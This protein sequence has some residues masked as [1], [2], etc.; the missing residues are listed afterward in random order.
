MYGSSSLLVTSA[1][2]SKAVYMCALVGVRCP[3]Q[4]ITL[5]YEYLPYKRISMYIYEHMYVYIYI[6]VNMLLSYVYIYIYVHMRLAEGE[7]KCIMTM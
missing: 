5:G 4:T 1:N 3:R 7:Y 6:Y 2:L